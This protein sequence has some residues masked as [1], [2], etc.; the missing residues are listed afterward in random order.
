LVTVVGA[1]GASFFTPF[2]PLIGFDSLVLEGDELSA[3][4]VN[5]RLFDDSVSPR[6]LSSRIL[7]SL[8]EFLGGVRLQK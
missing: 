5:R 4:S 8:D 1:G 3:F 2:D 7:R 6:F